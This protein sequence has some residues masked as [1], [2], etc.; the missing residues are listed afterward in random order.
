MKWTTAV[1]I[2]LISNF[3]YAQ[4]LEA[5]RYNSSQIHLIG[6][7]GLSNYSVKG[8][9]TVESTPRTASYGIEGLF[10]LDE[11]WKLFSSYNQTT[12][13]MKTSAGA[14]PSVVA[15][16][17]KKFRIAATTQLFKP[18]VIFIDNAYFGLGYFHYDR[19]SDRSGPIDMVSD[20]TKSG[21]LFTY[22]YMSPFND[23]FYSRLQL[24]YGLITR[25]KEN[26]ATTGS[27]QSGYF[28]DA[29][30]M[31]SYPISRVIDFAFGVYLEYDSLTFN[32]TGARG[33]TDAKEKTM[34]YGIPLEINVFF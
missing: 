31:L 34:N 16:Q 32:G 25:F 21:P 19:S 17:T 27:Y 20:V 7:L 30:Y 10:N 1:F 3:V 2:L 22:Q 11:R 18:G 4:N 26:S 5:S 9:S 6:Q 24:E 12:V 13:E 23:L 28:F 29:K 8:S 15:G 14:S 33:I